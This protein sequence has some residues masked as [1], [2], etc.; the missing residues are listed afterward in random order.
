MKRRSFLKNSALAAI[1]LSVAGNEVMAQYDSERVGGAKLKLSLN[2]YSFNQYLREGK[3]SLDELLEFCAQLGFEAIDP[4]GYYF[5][6]YPMAPKDSFLYEFKRKAHILGLDISGTGVKNDF[7]VAEKAKREA[8][9]KMIRDWIEVSAKMG[10]PVLRVFA[11]KTNP[12][13]FTW[14]QIATWMADDLGE[15][16][17][18]AAK[19]G[20]ILALQNHAEFIKTSDQVIRILEM[21]NSKWLGLHLDIGSFPTKDP[22]IDI[23]KTVKYAV[24]WQIKE[25]V[26][27]L[28]RVVKTDLKRLF[29]IIRKEKYRGY[30]P[31]ETLGPGDPYQKVTD[32]LKQVKKEL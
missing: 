1:G 6:G 21:V 27:I 2:A 8:D 25:N 32:F 4:T 19:Y 10:A 28:D 24:N 22:Y 26:K 23:E 11:G 14:E 29:E 18:Y 9:K 16:A 12:E 13:N 7:T 5:P 3:I 31:L 15:C 20:V 30:L 17:E